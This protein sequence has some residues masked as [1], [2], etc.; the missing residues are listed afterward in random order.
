[1]DRNDFKGV[2]VINVSPVPPIRLAMLTKDEILYLPASVLSGS[3]KPKA[4][5]EKECP[6]PN[7]A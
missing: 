1:V 5:L 4:M 7:G 3:N 2:E 6:D